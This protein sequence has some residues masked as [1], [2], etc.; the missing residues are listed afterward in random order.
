MK[1][2]Y[3]R[4]K[5]KSSTKSCRDR[6]TSKTQRKLCDFS[7][8]GANSRWKSSVSLR[9]KFFQV[10][11]WSA[12]SAFTKPNGSYAGRNVQIRG[13]WVK[14]SPVALMPTFIACW[15]NGNTELWYFRFGISARDEYRVKMEIHEK[16]I[17]DLQQKVWHLKC[18]QRSVLMCVLDNN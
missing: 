12:V 6:S 18:M 1:S 16:T 15:R 10:C 17:S 9:C 2:S 8:H 14:Y 11:C 3:S 5:M 7:P 13:L 4:L